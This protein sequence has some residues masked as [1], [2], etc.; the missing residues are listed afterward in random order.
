MEGLPVLENR[1]ELCNLFV[2][3][4]VVYD[5]ARLE[6]ELPENYRGGRSPHLWLPG[7]IDPEAWAA[8]DYPSNPARIENPNET[9][10][11]RIVRSK[12]EAII[13]SV[14]EG[15]GLLHR[16][17]QQIIIMGEVFYPDFVFLLP[18]TRRLIYYEHFGKMDDPD[19]VKKVMHK[20]EMYPYYGLYLGY[21]F[22]VS[23]E[24]RATPFSFAGAKQNIHRILALD[25][26]EL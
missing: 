11:G 17:E 13:G 23:F 6:L 18:L 24:T 26:I 15:A 22:F 4:D 14:A 25:N 5:P 8:A 7:D 16:Y 12:S 21:D 1:I 19:Y 3:N 10:N 20:L 2:E 9:D